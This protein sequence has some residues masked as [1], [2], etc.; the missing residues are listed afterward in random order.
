MTFMPDGQMLVT[1]R[2]GTLRVVT[3]GGDVATVVGTPAVVAD[4]QGG[5]LDVAL[6]PDFASNRVVYLTFSER[7]A[8]GV[9]LA[10]T[11]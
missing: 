3:T 7:G 11:R 2:G 8:D 5:L 1:E 9:G 4:G 10:V 6:D